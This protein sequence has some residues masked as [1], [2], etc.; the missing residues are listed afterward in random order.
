MTF[1]IAGLAYPHIWVSHRTVWG[2]KTILRLITTELG[3]KAAPHLPI[4]AGAF[5]WREEVTL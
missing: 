2:Q 1:Q 5:L 4:K 3:R